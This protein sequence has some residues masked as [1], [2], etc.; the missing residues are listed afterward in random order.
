MDILVELARGI[1]YT[2]NDT[3]LY[4]TDIVFIIDEAQMIYYDNGFWLDFVKTQSGSRFG[5]RIC[6]F[7]SYG[8]AEAGPSEA[9]VGTPLAYLGPKQRVS[10]TPSK[11]EFAPKISLFYNRAEF[12]DVVNRAC[13]DPIRPLRLE[14]SARDI[15]FTMTNG[16][17]GSVESVLNLVSQ[18]YHPQLKH[19]TIEAVTQ[20][21][22]MSLLEDEDRLFQHLKDTLVQRSFIKWRDLTVE[23][24]D[25]LREVLANGSVS[26]DLTNN[27]I[28][29]CYEK[30][31]LHTEPLSWDDKDIRCVFPTHLH[32]KYAHDPQ[33]HNVG[34]N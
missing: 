15:I 28:R 19:G 6:I 17:P 20:E 12:D 5:P 18:V 7:S 3:T 30:G 29:I 10:I 1:G 31:W 24:A 13:T 9:A 33:F 4:N 22:I 26:Q 11:L 2:V 25:I 23:A 34:S 8:S 16:H 14:L 27:G 21:H 32:A